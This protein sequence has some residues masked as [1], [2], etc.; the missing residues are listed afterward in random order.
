MAG[1]DQVAAGVILDQFYKNP[2]LPA[3]ASPEVVARAIQLGVQ[4]GALGLAM[5]ED[6][7][8][9]PELLRF[10]EMVPLNIISFEPG[11]FVISRERCEAL[12]AEVKPP[13]E[14]VAVGGGVED[15]T[16]G[17]APAGTDTGGA[18]VVADPGSEVP[19]EKKFNRVHLVIGDIPAS[20]IADVN[21][22]IFLPLSA[23]VDNLKFTLQI[24]VTSDEGVTQSTL[25]NKIKETIRQIGATLKEEKKE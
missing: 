14:E 22:G 24:D 12:L 21:R 3:P 7:Q 13:E 4:E 17:G 11:I 8:I 1:N 18:D 25:E 10:K 5:A 2:S 19:G 9:K 20:R 6:G 16:S 15:I 23:N